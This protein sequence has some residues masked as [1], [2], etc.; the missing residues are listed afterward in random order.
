MRRRVVAVMLAV[1]LGGAAPLPIEGQPART[2]Y[3][4]GVVQG[5][6]NPL[7]ARWWEA[8]FQELRALGWVEGQNI[9]VERLEADANG[10]LRPDFEAELTRLKLDVLV[11]SA[12]TT[13]LAVKQATSSIPIVLTVPGDPVA[14][15][16]VQSLA[17]PGGNVTGMSFVGTEL[18]SKQLDLIK[19]TMPG[20]SRVAVLSN[21]ANASHADRVRE[22]ERAARTLKLELDTVEAGTPGEIDKAFA[23]IRTRRAGALVVLGDPMFVRES[24][25]FLALASKNSL[26]VM[27][28]LREQV[29]AGGLM[30]YSASFSDLFRRAAAYVDKILR[31]AKPADL[32]VEQATKF[33]LVINLKTARALRLTIPRSVLVRADELIDQ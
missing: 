24:R 5:P 32:P 16:L 4:I 9:A 12:T 31:G 22:A 17:R 1:A 11:V 28:G 23:T 19:E 25:R 8:F 30:A 14:T 6:P 15:G 20:L 26:P 29:V 33:E 18:T 10:R 2:V 13:A 27:Y 7:V 21:P 3:R